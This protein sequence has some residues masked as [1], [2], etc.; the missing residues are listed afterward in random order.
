M[1]ETLGYLKRGLITPI[2][3]AKEFDASSVAEAFKYLLPGTHIGRV[4]I[5]IRDIDGQPTLK[6]EDKASITTLPQTLRLDP[7]A[8]YLLVG[9]LG[10]LGRAISLYMVEHGARHLVYLSRSAGQS[11]ADQEFIAELKSMAVA[12][13]EITLITVPGDITSLSDVCLAISHIP[14]TQHPLKGILQLTA[15]QADENF[16]RLSKQ[17]WDYSLGPKVTGTWNLHYASA[18]AKLDFFL[19]FSSMSSVIGLPGQAN[20]ASGNS[21][22]DAFVQFRNGL[23]L[24]CSA[25]DIGPVADVG[26]LSEREALLRTATLTG[27]KTLQEQE[28]LDAIGL[29]M[30]A[31]ISPPSP[32]QDKICS[33]SPFSDPNV[34]VLG[35]ESTIP[36][37]SPSNRAVWK[38]DRRMA[39]Y[40]NFSSSSSSSSSTTTDPSSSTDILKTYLASARADPSLLKSPTSGA[41]SFFATEIGKRLFRLLLKDERDLNTS[42]A[43]SDLGLDSLVAIELRAWWKGAFGFDISVLEMLSLGSLQ[44]LGGFVVE[45]LVKGFDEAEGK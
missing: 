33:P 24:P 22:L 7:Q 23:G 5:R 12:P 27:F 31:K 1:T 17:Q 15:V 30:M 25:V 42:L 29:S 14:T 9:G 45:R 43:L 18:A 38:K 11:P 8:S 44:A 10:G 20:Y 40:H 37:D 36:L 4:G 34:F 19:L 6:P 32:S 41:S 35:L 2:P 16:A 3:I 26:F 13:E 28:M 21:F 39:I